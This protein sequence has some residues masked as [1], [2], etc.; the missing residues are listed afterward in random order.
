MFIQSKKKFNLNY[1]YSYH[2]NSC[3][4]SNSFYFCKKGKYNND[5]HNFNNKNHHNNNNSNNSHNNNEYNNNHK[6]GFFRK[7][8]QLKQ[9]CC[10]SVF[11]Q[12]MFK[13]IIHAGHNLL[14]QSLAVLQVSL[15]LAFQNCL[16]Q[17]QCIMTYLIKS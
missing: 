2:H 3:C 13:I 10:L 6:Y 8:E 7:E 14:I 9:N 5:Y 11:L 4:S 12:P 1:R 15:V 17:L 16:I